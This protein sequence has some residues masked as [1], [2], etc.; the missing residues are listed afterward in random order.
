MQMAQLSRDNDY[1]RLQMHNLQLQ[2]TNTR[3]ALSTERQRTADA[4]HE[5]AKL[6]QYA[7]EALA[8][9]H[10]IQ[11]RSS[12]TTRRALDIEQQHVKYQQQATLESRLHASAQQRIRELEF[13]VAQSQQYEMQLTH[14]CDTYRADMRKCK[15]DFE[16]AMADVNE[17]RLMA[18]LC[19]G[20]EHFALLHAHPHQ[21]DSV[22]EQA[23]SGM[24]WK[25]TCN[26]DA[27]VAARRRIYTLKVCFNFA[28]SSAA[29]QTSKY[30]N[31]F[32]ALA[33]LPAHVNVVRFLCSFVA[34]IPEQLRSMLPDI[35]R[36]LSQITIRQAGAIQV[37]NRKT[38][39]Y[40]L[41][42]L[43]LT[44]RTY[45]ARYFAESAMVP[46]RVIKKVVCDVGSALLH[47]EANR[48]A[49]R[50]VT[51]DTV[52]ADVGD[53]IDQPSLI[54]ASV[55]PMIKR[56]V[57]ADF[58]AACSLSA[59]HTDTVLINPNGQVIPSHSTS[60]MLWSSTAHIAPEVHEAIDVATHRARE[61]RS[62]LAV[63]VDYS[64]QAVFELGVLTCEI[65]TG[66]NG[67]IPNYLLNPTANG[68]SHDT[69]SPNR[70]VLGREQSEMLRRAVT[71]DPEARPTVEQMMECFA[72]LP[73][74]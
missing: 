43:P 27:H 47:L 61:S 59:D 9:T 23:D 3:L 38:Q 31:E 21:R 48:M 74:Q 19:T 15:R 55:A 73:E 68:A 37:R 13:L 45:L 20:V 14:E 50:N 67:L 2:L 12:H 42:Y 41:E 5:I 39:F 35:P 11:Q 36:E 28:G 7:D 17:C 8:Q 58:G 62:T 1:L 34:A 60:P 32:C 16:R 18:A 6:Q 70:F 64:K 69:L 29:V 40:V 26:V 44:L 10:Q 54:H 63:S 57:L 65:L 46:P 53:Q 22:I 33:K 66:G 51:L 72:R 52:W 49:H 56:C 4:L 30:V 24:A 71:R 25:V